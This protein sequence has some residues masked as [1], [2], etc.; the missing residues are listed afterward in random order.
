MKNI[1]T[2]TEQARSS[3]LVQNDGVPKYRQI[4]KYLLQELSSGKLSQ[5]DRIPSEK[6]L[7][8]IFNVSRITSKKALEML[9]EN[10][11]ISRQR[12]RGSFV[13]GPQKDAAPF[14]SIVLLL[15]AFNDSFG[16]RLV[17]SV[18]TACANF[19]YNLIL[20]L[21]RESLDEEEKALRTLDDKNVVG[22]LMIPI[23]GEHYN[24][25][26]LR[27]ILN[28]RPLVFVDRKMRGLPAPSVSSDCI[29]ASEMAV[30]WLLDQGHRNIA[31]YSGPVLHTSTVEDQQQGFTQAFAQK[32]IP[33]NS[34][35]IVDTLTSLD[36]LDTIT[37][38]LSEHPEISAAFTAEFEIALQVRRALTSL[39][40]QLRDFSLITF[41]RPNYAT[42]FPELICIRQDEDTIGRKAVEVL[43]RII[44]GESSQSIHDI[45]IPAE[46]ITPNS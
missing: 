8:G 18:E 24:N 27:Q 36:S 44:Q 30:S 13:V 10:K 19:G 39:G 28:K 3:G 6:E 41:D 9:T 20:K 5:G 26:I 37:R 32:N 7:S 14:C 45:L 31:F 15:S 4:Y 12:G 2:E 38:H 42:E 17:C 46:F 43:H 22:I 35:Y 25:E 29:T 11:L 34:A 16:N 40:R 1:G 23:H 33:L 21:T